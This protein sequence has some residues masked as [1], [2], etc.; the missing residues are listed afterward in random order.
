MAL[1]RVG[2]SRLNFNFS[3]SMRT[4]EAARAIMQQL[5]VMMNTAVVCVQTGVDPECLHNFRIAVRRQHALLGQLRGVIP[6]RNKQQLSRGFAWLNEVTGRTRDLDIYLYMLEAHKIKLASAVYDDL[7]LLREFLQ[8]QRQLAHRQLVRQ[9]KSLR[10]TK[11]IANWVAYLAS[12]LPVRSKLPHAQRPLSD[13]ANE[14]I[15]HMLRRVRKQG[16]AIQ[17][18]SPPQDLH[19][20]RKSCKKLRYLIEFFQSSYPATAI[21]RLLNVLALLQD[22][23]GEY[24]DLQV[25]QAF[26][27][28]FQQQAPA[29]TPMMQ[30]TL[31]AVDLMRDKL[32]K[33]KIKLRK[34][35][36]RHF[37]GF[38]EARQQKIF[39][40]LFK[41]E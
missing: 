7:A 5:L 3:A 4:D 22:V 37:S 17:A 6:Q 40:Q 33:R 38:M 21:K 31:D 9:L 28:T 25:Q 32:E 8:H 41:P 34:S 14:R 27:V 24:Q 26:V 16:N 29:R 13:F 18:D 39:K 35:F 12:P 19:A 20:L 2:A 23:L 1:P 10:Y 30:R 15:W 11:L 36:R